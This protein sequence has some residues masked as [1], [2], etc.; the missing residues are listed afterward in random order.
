MEIVKV[1]KAHIPALSELAAVTFIE[2]FGYLFSAEDLQS[3]IATYY[4]HDAL[5]RAIEDPEGFWRI[6]FDRDGTAV[7]Y[8]HVVPVQ[9]PHDS[10]NSDT[11]G[12][13]KRLYI[14]QSHQGQGIGRALMDTA[15]AQL[16]RRFPK[17]AH[18]ISVWNR[19]EKAIALY[20]SYG[21]DKAGEWTFNVGEAPNLMFILRRTDSRR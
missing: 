12:E 21:F 14:R 3:F 11:D 4:G 6:A 7:G 17:G 20:Q 10:A 19:N 2:T 1:T 16:D 13:L 18:W 5:A 8:V 15:I 9:L